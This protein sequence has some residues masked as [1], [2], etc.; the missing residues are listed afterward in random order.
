MTHD[1]QKRAERAARLALLPSTGH[2]KELRARLREARKRKGLTLEQV[3]D[4]VAEYLGL[5]SFSAG[6][7]SHYEAFRRHPPVDVM[8][9]WARAV[10]LKLVVDLTGAGSDDVGVPLPPRVAWIARA[11]K[12]ADDE[13]LGVVETILRRSLPL[14]PEE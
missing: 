10:D 12:G 1:E 6:A 7:I 13:I 2:S 4:S 3:A 5:D 9:A 14:D 8:A 11:L